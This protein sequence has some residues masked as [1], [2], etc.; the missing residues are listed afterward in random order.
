[1]PDLRRDEIT[2]HYEVDGRGPPLLL[3]AGMLSDS[4]TWAGLLPM[5][6]EKF[7]V[8]RPDNR[9]TGRTEPKN[10]PA[11]PALMAQDALA[12]MD[13]LGHHRFHCAGHSLGGLLTLEL[14]SAHAGRIATAT[15]LASGR[16]RSP[17]TMA[18]FDSLL[19]IRQAPQG[20]EM[21]LRALYPWIF[22]DRFFE[23][24]SN[25]QLALDAALAYPHAQ[26]VAAM[27]HQIEAFR[28]FHPQADPTQVTS[29]TLVL[30]AG[31]DIM[32]PPGPAK[33]SFSGLPN[34]EHHVIGHAGHSIV[35]DATDEVAAHL[36]W[37]LGAH[38][39]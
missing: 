19:A 24:P 6:T 18:L 37:F 3:L 4:A 27:A 35:W 30:Y 39:I 31:K 14:A 28:N 29:P 7:T 13:H 1:M 33:E 9:T 10:A 25:T 34:A 38:P 2:L 12:L 36:Q 21:W 16:V 26:P 17:R 5:L 11:D 15:V 20:E 32:L 23:D 22:G 8:I